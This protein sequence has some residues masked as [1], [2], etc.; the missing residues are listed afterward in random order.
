MRWDQSAA[1]TDNIPW[2]RKNLIGLLRESTPVTHTEAKRLVR[3][4]LDRK[5]SE[6]ELTNSVYA[7]SMAQ[8]LR[9]IGA[10]VEVLFH[11]LEM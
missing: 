8:T 11:R 1:W 3:D 6:I 5:L 4:V 9:A 10:T 2:A 7:E